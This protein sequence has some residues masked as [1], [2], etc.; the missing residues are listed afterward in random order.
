MNVIETITLYYQA[1]SSDK[2]Y[3]ISVIDN[4]DATF[5]VPFCYGRR[6]TSGQV[7][8]K[9][10]KVSYAEAAKAKAKVVTQKM[11]KGYAEGPSW[12][13]PGVPVSI[14]NTPAPKK[15]T[16]KSMGSGMSGGGHGAVPVC[17]LLDEVDE[18]R[19]MELL[20]DPEY[21]C[22]EKHDGR[23]RTMLYDASKV[24]GF[25]K[26]GQESGFI[27]EFEDELINIANFNGSS[28]FLLDGEEVKDKYWVFDILE[29][30][31]ESLDHL[32][33]L[34]K[35]NILQKLLSDKLKLNHIRLVK[36]CSNPTNK[37]ALW[38]LLHDEDREGIV[39]KRIMGTHKV[40]K[41]SGDHFKYKFYATASCIVLRVNKKRSIGLKL[42]GMI[43]DHDVGNCTIPPNKEIP[44]VDDVVEIRYLYA[45]KGG[46]LY[47]PTYLGVRDDV[48]HMECTMSQL[49]FKPEDE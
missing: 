39:F 30:N 42:L 28:Q 18:A 40:G 17:Q 10:H 23:R 6:G 36:T 13:A 20:D 11:G 5:S 48:E 44:K 37:K 45:Y 3:T 24:L 1:G 14:P 9:V 33:Y 29:H 15:T 26:K 8:T 38:E 12:M 16:P 21:C 27:P 46:S 49:K 43:K 32:T 4:G 2:F 25:N 34:Q 7:G 35:Y 22:Q 41:G 19:A 47:Q 31:G